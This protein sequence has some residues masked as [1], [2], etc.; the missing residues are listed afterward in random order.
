MMDRTDRHF[1]VFLRQL[2]RHTL[3][4]TEMVTTS[5]ILHGDRDYLLG[6]SPEERPLALQL[7]G[8]D[9]AALATAARIAEDFGYDEVNLNCGCPSDRVQKGR[10]GA[11][12]MREPALVAEAVGAMRAAT[13]LPVTVKH[14]VGVDEL[15][16]YEDMLRFVDTVASAGCDR[17][18]VHARKAWLQGLSPRENREVPPLRHEDV[19]RLKAARPALVIETNGQV[20]TLNTIAS[21]LEHV[22]AV[23][24]GRAAFEDPYLFAHVD[25]R[26]FGDPTPP[27]SREEVVERLLPYV[28]RV[29]AAGGRRL[30]VLK[31]LLTLF[32]RQPGT[33][34]WKRW[35]STPHPG[36]PLVDVL[37]AGL[38]E[39]RWSASSARAVASRPGQGRP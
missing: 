5:A 12:L 14:R 11:V 32:A 39:R 27:P 10:F 31:H 34:A 7:G 20:R 16:R 3:L 30:T 37:R 19:Y 21:H 4:Y 23:M 35:L 29:E 15:D 33:R 24:I 28:A 36:Q 17:F 18:T 26:F 22:D 13:S 6:F 38:A 2:T 8:S 25:Q 1:R 9:P